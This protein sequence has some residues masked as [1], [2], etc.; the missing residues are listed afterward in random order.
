MSFQERFLPSLT[1]VKGDSPQDLAGAYRL[2]P[3]SPSW[4]PA[5][6]SGYHLLLAG[7]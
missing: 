7:S 3:F 2:Q 5:L 6:S 4:F 1:P